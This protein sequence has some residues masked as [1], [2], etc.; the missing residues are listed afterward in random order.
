MTHEHP[1][2]PTG[3]SG[4]HSLPRGVHL[5]GSVP[6]GSAEEVFRTASS[7]LGGRLRRIPDGETGV[8]TNWI[9]W[10]FPFLAN[11]PRMEI[12]PPDPNSG[13]LRPWVKLRSPVTSSEITFDQPGYADAAQS[14]YAVFSQLKQ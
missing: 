7:I 11:N 6:L 8:R 1:D 2:Y 10:Q 14:S 9:A 5:V 3:S 4:A 13:A 12:V